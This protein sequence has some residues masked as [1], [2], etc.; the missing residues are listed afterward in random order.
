MSGF[1]REFL[2]VRRTKHPL[3]CLSPRLVLVYDVLG[4]RGVP[5]GIS[6]TLLLSRSSPR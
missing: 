1:S 3:V 2:R 6:R 5:H 4:S